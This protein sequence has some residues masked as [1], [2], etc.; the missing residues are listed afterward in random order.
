M[1][2]SIHLKRC[3][4]C[5]EDKPAS[6]EFFNRCKRDTFKNPCRKCLGVPDRR[7]GKSLDVGI[8][9][10][11]GL[12]LT[13]GYIAVVDACDADLVDSYWHAKVRVG[14][15]AVYA[16]RNSKTHGIRGEEHLHRIILS[17][18]IGRRLGEAEL[19]DH[20][21]G[22]GLNNR[23]SNLRVATVSENLYN[24]PANAANK[25]GYKGVYLVKDSNKYAATI[26]FNNERLHLGTFQ[27]PELAYSAYCKA[28]EKYHGE[29]ARFE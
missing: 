14:R 1:T 7:I 28:A 12:P 2:T 9:G 22:D 13:K 16:A 27:T 6:P 21:D 3:S 11:V 20:I 5:G 10:V 29:F 26:S 17:R 4:R 25:T 19:V 15:K 8:S 18:V 24:A 23:R